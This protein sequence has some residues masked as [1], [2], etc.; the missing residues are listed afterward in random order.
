M[1]KEDI[2]QIMTTNNFQFCDVMY[3]LI[4]NQSLYAEVSSLVNYYISNFFRN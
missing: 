4:N 2:K 1:N 3:L